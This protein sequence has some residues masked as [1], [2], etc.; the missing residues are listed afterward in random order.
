MINN[1]NERKPVHGYEE[2][3]GVDCCVHLP[4]VVRPVVDRVDE[5]ASV[6]GIEIDGIEG[7]E[8]KRITWRSR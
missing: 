5:K 1:K 6:K 7:I 8:I 2:T 4:K 3:S